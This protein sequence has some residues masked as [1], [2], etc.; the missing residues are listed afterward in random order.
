[1]NALKTRIDAV[2][3]KFTITVTSHCNLRCPT[4]LYILS[5]S[6]FFNNHFTLPVER[7]E[8]ILDTYAEAIKTIT[9]T[10]GEP[11]LHPDISELVDAALDR[12]IDVGMASNGILIEKNMEIMQKLSGHF[13][14]SLDGWDSRSYDENREGGEEQWNAILRGMSLL[15]EA[16]VEFNT[17][18]LITAANIDRMGDMIEFAQGFSPKLINLHSINEHGNDIGL[19]L[20]TSSANVMDKFEQVMS[21]NDYTSSISMPVIFDDT[22]SHFKTKVCTYPFKGVFVNGLGEIAYCCHLN[23]KQDIGNLFEGYDFNSS[24]MRQWRKMQIENRFPADCR[25]C[26]RRF[27]GEADVFDAQSRTWTV[28]SRF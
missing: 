5:G 22:S 4:C 16:G 9:L 21:R 8:W 3:A 28:N 20:T 24:K 17:S 10:G 13:Q 15:N 12:G 6:E 7:F 14:I 18:F 25:Y 11:L 19:A 1:M 26:H 2:P 27:L 23:H